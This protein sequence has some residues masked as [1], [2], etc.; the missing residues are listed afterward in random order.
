MKFERC[1]IE[2]LHVSVGFIFIVGVF[3]IIIIVIF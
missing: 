3:E 1:C 2:K